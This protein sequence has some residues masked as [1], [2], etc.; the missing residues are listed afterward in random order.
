[1]NKITKRSRELRKNPTKAEKIL[2]DK[3]RNKKLGVKFRRQYPII[4]LKN[5]VRHYFIAD[6]VNLD[7]KVV[8]ELDGEIHNNQ[9]EYDQLRTDI[10][11]LLGYAVYRFSN[12]EIINKIETVIDRIKN[13]CSLPHKNG[14]GAVGGWGKQNK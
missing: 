6:F 3:I 4:I 11:N 10:I 14:E 13:Y 1:M 9:K 8:I 12:K 5:K 2:W 7:K